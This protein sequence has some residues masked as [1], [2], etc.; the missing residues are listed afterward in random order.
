MAKIY[1]LAGMHRS[2][3]S[4]MSS[5]LIACDIPMGDEMLSAGIGNVHGHFEDK[6]ILEFH[7]S[8]LNENV[9]NTYLPKKSVSYSQADIQQ[10]KDIIATRNKSFQ[11]WGWKD[12][13][14]TLLL[15]LWS[16]CGPEIK[17][18]FMYRE[19]YEVVSSL[20]R[21]IRKFRSPLMFLMP[22]LGCHSWLHYNN[23]ILDFCQKNPEKSILISVNGFVNDPEN[24]SAILQDW[25]SLSSDRSFSD[26]FHPGDM[27]TGDDAKRATIYD[28]YQS[29]VYYFYSKKMHKMHK[30]LDSIAKTSSGRG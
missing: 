6:E 7:K 17:F 20:C 16:D 8:L 26:I 29:F 11:V 9:I 18:V 13:R 24:A 30:M 25:L 12:P 4:L 2:G 28:K 21:R 27:R 23:K 1:C 14:S 15:D 5:Y 10:A 19:P 3:T 22:W